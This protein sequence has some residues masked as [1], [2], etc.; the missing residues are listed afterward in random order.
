MLTRD[1]EEIQKTLE[2][3][4]PFVIPSYRND[5]D[6]HFPIALRHFLKVVE[7]LKVDL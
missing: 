6:E 5:H 4:K 3:M 2:E 7:V 1:N